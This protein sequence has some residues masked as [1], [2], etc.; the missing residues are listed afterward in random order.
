LRQFAGGREVASK[1]TSIGPVLVD[2][3]FDGEKNH[4]YIRKQLG[5]QSVITA[6][7]EKKSWRSRGVR[8]EIRRA[9]RDNS[10]AAD[11]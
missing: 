4:S 10:I 9:S 2:A 3:K 1:Q 5:A 7:R 11:P 6:K 8:A